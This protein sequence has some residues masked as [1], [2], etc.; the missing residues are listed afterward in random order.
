MRFKGRKPIFSDKDTWSLDCTLSPII[1]AGLVKFKEVTERKDVAGYPSAVDSYEEW[2]EILE[3]MIFA[4]T[5][6][7]PKIPS[8]I[9]DMVDLGTDEEG[10]TEHRIDIVDQEKHDKY[11]KVENEYHTKVAEGLKLFGEHFRSLWW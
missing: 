6:K 4:F 1:G 9:Y 8:G 7:E 5:A 10:Y 2:V 11:T 3:K